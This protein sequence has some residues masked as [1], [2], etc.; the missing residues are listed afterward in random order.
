MADQLPG[1]SSAQT[2]SVFTRPGEDIRLG[3]SNSDSIF[4]FGDFR[5]YA[6]TTSQALTGTPFNLSFDGFSTLE[7]LSGVNFTP[8]SSVYVSPAELTSPL[9]EP[10][11]YTYFGSFYSD[12]A[13]SINDII[14][15]FP[16]AILS[17]DSGSGTTIYDYTETYNNFTLLKTSTFKIPYSTLINQGNILVGTGSP[18]GNYNLLT[19]YEEFA[20]QMRPSSSSA[21]TGVYDI[22]YYNFSSDTFNNYY[23]EFTING[24]LEDVTGSTSTLP[25]LIRPNEKRYANY[26]LNIDRLEYNL[27]YGEKLLVPNVEDDESSTEKQFIWPKNIDEFNPDTYGN[28]FENY[29]TSILK[30]AQT[31]DEAKTN[32]LLKTVLPENYVEL[33]SDNKIYRTITQSYAN[34]FDE[35]KQ[36]IDNIAYAHSVTYNGQESVPTKFMGKLSNLL[37]W[38]LSDSFSDLDLFEYLASDVTGD[39]NSFSYFNI[40]IWKRILVNIVWLYKKKGT[41][42]AIQFL[43]KLMG[44]PDCMVVF[45]EFVYDINRIAANNFTANTSLVKINENGYINTLGSQYIF[46]EG[47]PGRGDGQRYINQWTPEFDPLKR[48]DNIKVVVGDDAVFGSENILNTKEVSISLDPAA[49][50]ECDVFSF[51][52]Q[53]GTC[54]VWGSLYPSFSS[55]TVPFE[56]APD[57]SVASPEEITGMTFAQYLEYVYKTA[58]N[59]RNRKTLSQIHTSFY[60]PELRN[61]Y[62]NYYLWSNPDSNRLTFH[63]LQSFVDLL[64]INF[65]SYIEQMIPATTI[66]Q[67]AGTTIRNTVFNRQKFVYKDGIND[68]SEFQW[69]YE[70]L[71][72]SLNP[73]QVSSV[74]ND[75]ISTGLTPITIIGTLNPSYSTSI[76]SIELVAQINVN[77]FAS[78]VDSWDT[79]AEIYP[80]VKIVVPFAPTTLTL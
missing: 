20:I 38:K 58:P 78:D 79:T 22:L 12:V 62:L 32:I 71:N 70:V 55:L 67:H 6:D 26:V 53:S 45:D 17:Y 39:N 7:S 61:I 59:P 10:T 77:N 30:A 66:L 23:L 21:Q 24:F 54:W 50:I 2:L 4:T 56:Y 3:V 11:S 28:D 37:G 15:N 72:P 73:I 46:Q 52:Q 74:V 41:R 80:P 64:E 60:Y 5:V 29:K 47:G 27:L 14:Q 76:N 19:D 63:K 16:Y 34:Q 18:I 57:C 48:V 40:E 33:D 49:A 13:M 44:A 65:N 69:K 51:Y 35:I 8:P 68:G 9:N 25:I 1:P 43:F 42:D 36:Y 31:I 75:Y